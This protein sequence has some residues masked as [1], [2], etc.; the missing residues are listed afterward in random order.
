MTNRAIPDSMTVSQARKVAAELYPTSN[1][2]LEQKTM[3][4]LKNIGRPVQRRGE[5][6]DD[7]DDSEE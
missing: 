5:S 1:D 4:L 2:F 3:Y 6:L 7:E